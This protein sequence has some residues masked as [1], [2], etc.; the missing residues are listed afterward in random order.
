M[1]T[2]YEERILPTLINWACSS[3]AIMEMRRQIVPQCRGIVLEVGAGSGI[4]FEFYDSRRVSRVHALEPSAAMRRKGQK[5]W[6]R[7]SS[8]PIDWCEL[9]GEQIALPDESVDTVLL[10]FSLCSISDY[11]GALFQIRRVLKQ[12]GQ[13]IFCEHGLSCDESVVRLQDRLTPFWAKLAGGCHLN[14]PIFRYL[15]DAGFD[16]LSQHNSY[17]SRVPRFAGYLYHGEARKADR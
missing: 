14:R 12:D 9:P 3:S 8:V 17:L 1:G 6:G 10:T 11:Q 13:L 4:N 16:I 2:W 15:T 7:R 5:I